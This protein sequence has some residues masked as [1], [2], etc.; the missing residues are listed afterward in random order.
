MSTTE[1]QKAEMPINNEQKKIITV[2]LLREKIMDGLEDS[3]DNKLAT[4]RLLA[5]KRAF[6]DFLF[7]LATKVKSFN[8]VWHQIEDDFFLLG[9]TFC[10]SHVEMNPFTWNY[11][12]EER[13]QLADFLW[14]FCQHINY[15]VGDL[16]Y[17]ICQHHEAQTISLEV[18]E[19]LT[20]TLRKAD[21]GLYIVCKIDMESDLEQIHRIRAN[22][23]TL[24]VKCDERHF[25]VYSPSYKQA[26]QQ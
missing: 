1:E 11:L 21:E 12:Q 23:Y 25:G 3:Q 19:Y 7:E 9:Y 24:R 14:R 15:V 18:D 17:F 6:I 8:D 22:S 10:L 13:K 5:S 20:V 16:N 26:I 2:S 4:P